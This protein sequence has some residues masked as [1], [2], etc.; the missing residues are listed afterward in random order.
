[1][2]ENEPTHKEEL[3]IVNDLIK[4]IDVAMFT[5]IVGNKPVSRPLQTQEAE[6][7]GDLWFLT[8]KDTDKYQEILQN[9]SVNV[10]YA[11]KS[12]VS[13]SGSAQFI[14]DL[15]RKKEYWNPVFD[16]LLNTTYDD[17]NV[18]LIKV[19]AETA[20]YWESGNMTK[21]VKNFAK[22]LT[23]NEDEGDKKQMNDTVEFN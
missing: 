10:A 15:E 19:T 6:F 18:I 8:L 9:P 21:T 23:G 14:D 5:T 17:P 22:K 4:D 20:E 11:G 16:K 2:A 7:D 13:I 3:K 12:Y 1:M